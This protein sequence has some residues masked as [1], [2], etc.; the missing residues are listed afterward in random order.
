MPTPTVDLVHCVEGYADLCG[1]GDSP[2]RCSVARGTIRAGRDETVESRAGPGRGQMLH[3]PR[4][5]GKVAR[6][7]CG[8]QRHYIHSILCMILT[9]GRGQVLDNI[10]Q[11]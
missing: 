8:K 1:D 5:T 7:Q 2:G 11:D 9:R 6:W 3:W 10:E 4:Q